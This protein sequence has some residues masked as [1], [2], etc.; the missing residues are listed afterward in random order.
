MN[1]DILLSPTAWLGAFGI[2]L[3]RV[4]SIAL[5][6]IR[7]ML[8]I[9]GKRGLSWI[10]GFVESVIFVIIMGVV[11]NDLNNVLNIIGYAAGFATGTVVG[12]AIENRLAIGYSHLNIISRQRG[13][14]VAESLRNENYAVTEIP[15]RGKD[16]TVTL[17]DCSIRRKQ[18]KDVESLILKADPEAFITVEDITPMRHGYWH[19]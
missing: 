3:L 16:G 10:L 8:T 14:A 7:F 5:D 11:L 12:M 6:T 17:L 2:F 1:M 9:R 18:I 13:Q 4:I 15:A 19:S